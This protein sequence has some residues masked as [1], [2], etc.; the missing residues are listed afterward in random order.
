ML[1]PAVLDA[2]VSHRRPYEEGLHQLSEYLHMNGVTA[3]NE[4]GIYWAI[5]PWEMFKKFL[6]PTMCRST[7][8]SWL[9]EEPNRSAYRR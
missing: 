9:R 2:G 1:A 5:E 3:I 7:Q 8:R 4:P 6:A